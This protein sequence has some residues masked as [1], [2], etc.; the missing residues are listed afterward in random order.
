MKIYSR[1]ISF[2]NEIIEN[3]KGPR[4]LISVLSNNKNIPFVLEFELDTGSKINIVCDEINYILKYSKWWILNKH[5]TIYRV[6]SITNENENTEIINRFHKKELYINNL[7]YFFADS[8]NKK[9]AAINAFIDI[10]KYS[11]IVN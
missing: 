2:I 7:W 1:F 11:S 10:V 8:Q 5:I 9:K 6:Y 4:E 3:I